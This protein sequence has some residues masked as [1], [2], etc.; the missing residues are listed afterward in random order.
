MGDATTTDMPEP[1]GAGPRAAAITG[2]QLVELVID[3]IDSN[4]RYELS[5]AVAQLPLT[6]DRAAID[7]TDADGRLWRVDV[8][9]QPR[10]TAT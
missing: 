5:A 9:T 7:V 6:R 4:D 8:H 3:L 2:A 1:N 10:T